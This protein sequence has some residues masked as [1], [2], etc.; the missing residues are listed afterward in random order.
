MATERFQLIFEVFVLLDLDCNLPL[1]S[2]GS[3]PF[4]LVP[5]VVDES[6]CPRRKLWVEI[7]QTMTTRSFLVIILLAI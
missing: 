6:F 5:A 1:M 3:A 2:R 7:L 4:N